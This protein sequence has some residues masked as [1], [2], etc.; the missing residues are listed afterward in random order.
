VNSD[1]CISWDFLQ[2]LVPARSLSLASR[3]RSTARSSRIS[4]TPISS[5]RLRGPWSI[6]SVNRKPLPR[7]SKPCR[8]EFDASSSLASS[9]RNASQSSLAYDDSNAPPSGPRFVPRIICK[10]VPGGRGQ[11]LLSFDPDTIA[12][13]SSDLKGTNWTVL[14][15]PSQCTNFASWVTGRGRQLRRIA[16]YQQRPPTAYTSGY[17]T[18]GQGEH[19]QTGTLRRKKI[20]CYEG[21]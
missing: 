13:K 10:P 7:T 21:T 18:P 3:D 5:G 9:N 8:H 1:N 6:T 16:P 2:G 11:K 12:C 14:W 19:L 20:E 17:T 15:K 4:N